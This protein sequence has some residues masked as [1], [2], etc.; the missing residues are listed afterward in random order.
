MRSA[1][2]DLGYDVLPFRLRACC[3]GLDHQ[4]DRLFLLAELRDPHGERLARLD[5]QGEPAGDAGRATCRERR[6]GHDVLPPPRVCRG[7]DGIPDRVDRLR[8]LGNAVP[9]V[10][11]EWIGRRLIETANTED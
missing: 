5:R 4:R 2:R 11:A 6:G 9:P 8:S 7:T 10:M 3:L 1:L